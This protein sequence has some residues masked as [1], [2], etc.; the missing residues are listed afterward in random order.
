MLLL[1]L[2]SVE[3]LIDKTYAQT[4]PICDPRVT[5]CKPLPN[6]QNSS[7][8]MLAIFNHVNDTMG[9]NVTS[10]DFSMIVANLNITKGPTHRI[11]QTYDFMNGSETGIILQMMPGSF[12][13]SQNKRLSHPITQSYNITFSGDCHPFRTS[14][15]ALMGVGNIH[16]GQVDN[17]YISRTLFAHR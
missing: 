16:A 11:T 2:H 10:A 9:G 7:S 5:I 12:V 14:R 8:T 3:A 1:F 17:C 6:I 15:G 13:V 4:T